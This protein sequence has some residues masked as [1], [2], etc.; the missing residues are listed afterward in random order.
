M[1]LKYAVLTDN[2]ML[3]SIIEYIVAGVTPPNFIFRAYKTYIAS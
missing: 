3:F 2:A 1:S